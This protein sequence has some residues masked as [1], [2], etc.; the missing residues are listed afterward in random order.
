MKELALYLLL[1]QGGKSA[2]TAADVTKAG[3]AVG[4]TVDGDAVTQLLSAVEGKVRRPVGPAAARELQAALALCNAPPSTH[5]AATR[6]SKPPPSPPHRP[7]A[8]AEPG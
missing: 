7:P 1:V 8:A 3:E 2:P 6:A 5:L 4:I